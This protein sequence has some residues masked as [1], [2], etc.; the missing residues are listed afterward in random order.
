MATK[1][2]HKCEHQGKGDDACLTCNFADTQTSRKTVSI[3]AVPSVLD[4]AQPSEPSSDELIAASLG[5]VGGRPIPAEL[6]EFI[7]NLVFL[8]PRARDVFL[9][10]CVTGMKVNE[11]AK[12]LK[13]GSRQ[14]SQ[15]TKY[16][17][18]HPYFAKFLDPP[19]K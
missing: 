19:Q 17:R 7:R 10:L 2:C 3:D 8:Q 16:L 14:M 18:E 6:V 11:A 9:E 4:N 13:L 1:K 15:Y 12:N 5:K